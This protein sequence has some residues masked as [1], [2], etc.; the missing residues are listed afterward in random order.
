MD[1]RKENLW[2][3]KM[4]EEGTLIR[5]GVVP[6]FF[7]PPSISPDKRCFLFALLIV[8]VESPSL[9]AAS[10]C[11]VPA[12]HRFR[13]SSFLR[14]ETTMGLCMSNVGVQSTISYECERYYT[15]LTG[16]ICIR[17]ANVSVNKWELVYV[18][19]SLINL[20]QTKLPLA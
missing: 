20:K 12:L 9:S 14:H 11:V 6:T 7:R 3:N 19:D 2:S 17:A 15:W 18:V 4:R 8:E 13:A 1:Q 5:S 10:A 16:L